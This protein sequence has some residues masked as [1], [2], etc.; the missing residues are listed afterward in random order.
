VEPF[1][2]PH[3]TE[4]QMAALWAARMAEYVAENPEVVEALKSLPWVEKPETF[5]E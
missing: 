1:P 2:I 4:E 3:P 5:D